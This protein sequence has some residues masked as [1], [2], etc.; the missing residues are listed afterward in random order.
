MVPHLNLVLVQKSA[1]IYLHFPIP[2]H[3]VV[4][5]HKDNFTVTWLIFYCLEKRNTKLQPARSPVNLFNLLRTRGRKIDIQISPFRSALRCLYGV[6][7]KVG[8]SLQHDVS[9]CHANG[10]QLWT[11]ICFVLRWSPGYW[12]LHEHPA[13]TIPKSSSPILELTVIIHCDI[14]K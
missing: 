13:A 10:A 7:V 12:E 2:P 11:A 14:C 4:H 6:A 3:G 5:N 1:T 8:P 9:G